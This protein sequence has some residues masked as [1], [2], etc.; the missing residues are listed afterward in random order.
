M[1]FKGRRCGS[2]DLYFIIQDLGFTVKELRCFLVEDVRR[3][4]R[5][6]LKDKA[7]LADQV[8]PSASMT[9]LTCALKSIAIKTCLIRNEAVSPCLKVEHLSACRYSTGNGTLSR[10]LTRAKPCI[11]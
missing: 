6:H 7:A 1:D 10:W 11:A 2:V 4:E 3:F 8:Y 9:F 5:K